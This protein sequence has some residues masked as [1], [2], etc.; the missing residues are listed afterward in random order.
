MTKLSKEKY[1]KTKSRRK[2]DRDHGK[3]R[4]LH[5]QGAARRRD[6]EATGA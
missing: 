3:I 6:G 4:R 2:D 5:G 1:A